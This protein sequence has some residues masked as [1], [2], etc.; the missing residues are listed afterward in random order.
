M[1]TSR[2]LLAIAIVLIVLALLSL[3]GIV[4]K[5]AAVA[6]VIIGVLCA[7]IAMAMRR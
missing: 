4:L 1:S 5:G 2:L 3:L 7:V 6:L